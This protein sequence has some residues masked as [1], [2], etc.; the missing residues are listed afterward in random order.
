M[1]SNGERLFDHL[2]TGRAPLGSPVGSYFPIPSPGA[3]SL[4]FEYREEHSPGGIGDRL[5]KMPVF[6]HTL[7][8]EI[9]YG[10]PVVGLYEGVRDLVAEIKPLV[11]DL[12]V[13]LSDKTTSLRSTHRAFFSASKTLLGLLEKLLGFTKELRGFDLGSVSESGEGNKAHVNADFLPCLGKRDDFALD[14]EVDIPPVV[15]PSDGKGL[16]LTGYRPVPLNLNV[17]DVLKVETPVLD[18]TT[19]SEDSICDGIEPVGRFEPGITGFL[20]SLDP[21]EE[22]FESLVQPAKSLLER[23]VVAGG[24]GLVFLLELGEKPGGLLRESNAFAGNF[25]SLLPL[26]E[27]GVVEEAV[28]VK[29]GG[30]GFRLFPGRVKAV[31]ERLEHRIVLTEY[32]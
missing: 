11:G 17:A 21:A 23:T 26:S 15:S 4:G 5:R 22:R 31:F 24:K 8:I 27:G 6:D 10:K 1:N 12:L 29:L 18:L 25:V 3:F 19:V 13:D 28:P 20:P 30:K 32:A 2:S 14:G 16:D 9:F 7:D